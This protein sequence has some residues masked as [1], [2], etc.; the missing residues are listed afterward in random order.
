MTESAMNSD[1]IRSVRALQSVISN[2]MLPV[3]FEYCPGVQI[4]TDFCIIIISNLPSIIKD[5]LICVNSPTSEFPFV[6]SSPATEYAYNTTQDTRLSNNLIREWWARCRVS[7]SLLPE[8]MIDFVENDF[9]FA[10][11]NESPTNRDD[12]DCEA[13]QGK[14][15]QTF[16]SPLHNELFDALDTINIAED[17]S[18]AQSEEQ[19]YRYP[20]SGNDFNCWLTLSRLCAISLGEKEIS[21]KHWKYARKL[22]WARHRNIL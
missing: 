6:P 17:H 8:A 21:A 15:F 9:V 3:D 14:P 13:N 10:R 5:G 2:Q 22:E 16:K 7:E 11:R 18:E 1:A 20:V 12:D 4:P 19:L